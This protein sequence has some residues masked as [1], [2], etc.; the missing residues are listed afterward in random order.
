VEAHQDGSRVVVTV[1]D[2]GTGIA[3]EHLAHLG[4]RF[5]RIDDARSR[6]TGGTG[7]GLSICR[8]IVEAHGGSITF[9]SKVGVGTTVRVALPAGDVDLTGAH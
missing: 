3:S 5:Y 9:Q 6:P 8:G 2:T 1:T 7:L 4:E